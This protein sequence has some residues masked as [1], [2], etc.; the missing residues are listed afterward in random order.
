MMVSVAPR[1][2][3]RLCCGL[4]AAASATGSQRTTTPLLFGWRFQRG[5]LPYN[6]GPMLCADDLAAAFPTQLAGKECAMGPRD[7]WS[8]IEAGGKNN[9]PDDCARACCSSS[10]CTMWTWYNGSTSASAVGKKGSGA[11]GSFRMKGA[12]VL[13]YGS[14]HDVSQDC[15]TDGGEGW[16]GAARSLPVTPHPPPP[17]VANGAEAEGYDDSSWRTLSIPH[18]F[19]IEG[20]PCVAALGCEDPLANF[21][22][23]SYPKGVGWYRRSFTVGSDVLGSATGQRVTWLHFEGVLNDAMIFVNG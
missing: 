17:P 19:V 3:L 8:M 16:L 10:N 2:L 4:A 12:C 15:V 13:G 6:G 5:D 22:H 1:A 18:D 21:M 11:K 9:L 23:G 14:S 7:A 20:T